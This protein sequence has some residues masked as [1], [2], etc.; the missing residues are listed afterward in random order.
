MHPHDPTA[1][2]DLRPFVLPRYLD[3]D[4]FASFL[5]EHDGF[6]GLVVSGTTAPGPSG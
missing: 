1:D 4:G 3:R 2:E 6:E 5:V